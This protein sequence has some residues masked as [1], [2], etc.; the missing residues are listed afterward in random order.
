[1]RN[2]LQAWGLIGEGP[3]PRLANPE[4]LAGQKD[5]RAMSIVRSDATSGAYGRSLAMNF[6]ADEAPAIVSRLLQHAE[7]A[8]TEVIADHPN[9]QLS[10]SIPSDDAYMISLNLGAVRNKTY[11]EE[12]REI[13]EGRVITAL[14]DPKA[15]AFGRPIQARVVALIREILDTAPGDDKV[16][17]ERLSLLLWASA[18]GVISLQINKPTLPWPDAM[19]LVEDLMRAILRLPAT[20]EPKRKRS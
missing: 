2:R 20:P 1:M 17:A 5:V 10:H 12:G 7:F 4:C 11:W 6:G 9:A 3:D 8:V 16:D 18:H 19:S 13:G 15:A 14:S